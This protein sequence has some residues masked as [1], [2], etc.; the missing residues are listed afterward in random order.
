MLLSRDISISLAVLCSNGVLWSMFRTWC[1]AKR[2]GKQAIDSTVIG[3]FLIIT[4]GTLSNVFFLVS[5]CASVI[6]FVIFKKQT[7]IQTLLPTPDQEY[8]LYVYICTALALKSV[9]IIHDLAVCCSVN[10][11]FIDW[12][13]PRIRSNNLAGNG[14]SKPKSAEPIR[15]EVAKEETNNTEKDVETGLP[16]RNSFTSGRNEKILLANTPAVS[17]WR[18]YFVANEWIKLCGRRRLHL[19]VHILFVILTLNVSYR[20]SVNGFVH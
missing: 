8:D 12:E 4:C 5:T 2:A 11:F 1:W 18:T 14:N 6:W 10:I 17:I 13:T 9:Q 20:H 19:G 15:S 3:K 16:R 7:V